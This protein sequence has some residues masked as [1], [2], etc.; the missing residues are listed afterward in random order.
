MHQIFFQIQKTCAWIF[1]LQ[2]SGVVDAYLRSVYSKIKSNK[3]KL[4]L[5]MAAFALL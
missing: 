3:K 1:F 2:N 5:G 4:R